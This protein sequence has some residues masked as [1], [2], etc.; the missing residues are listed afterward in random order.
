MKQLS[1]WFLAVVLFAVSCTVYKEYPIDVYKPGEIAVPPNVKNI[2]LITRNFKYKNDTLQH[3]YK[4]NNLL[5]IAKGDPKNLDSILTN[6]CLNELAVN[7]KANKVC[8]RINIFPEVFKPHTGTKLPSID[9]ELIN[10][11][12]T[13]SEADLLISLETYSYFYSEYSTEANMPK[14]RE[15]ITANVWAVYDPGAK[16]IIERKTLID[17][18][19]W[20]S[21][22]EHGNYDKNSKLPPRLSALKI[23][24]QMAGE[25]YSKRFTAS[26]VSVKRMYSIPPL[27]DFEAAEKYLLKGDWDNAILLWKRYATDKNG[28]MAI[29]ARYNLALGYEMKDDMDTAIQWLTAAQ[30]IAAEYRSK[31]DIKRIAAYQK[32]LAQR[33]KEVERLNSN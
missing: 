14:S 26:W 24:S 32:V 12:T 10:K 2:A 22:D 9:F 33:K 18:V 19:Y 8:N 15:V 30:Q 25:N 16:K 31:E 23:A 6:T 28:K 17:T 13:A 29:N 11:L 7:L 4:D 1:F 27:P 20:N 21:Y 5:K 3:F